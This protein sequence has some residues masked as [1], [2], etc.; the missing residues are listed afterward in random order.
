MRVAMMGN[1]RSGSA[2][3]SAPAVVG[4]VV[5]DHPQRSTPTGGI[6]VGVDDSASARAAVA[7]A[8]AEADRRALE[9]HLV[10][11]LPSAGGSGG[12]DGVPHGRA[13]ALLF[14]AAGIA[15]ARCPSL[16]VTMETVSGRVGPALVAYSAHADL[17]VV[18]SNGPGGP[19]PLSLG[20]IL[21]EVTA[22]AECPVVLVPTTETRSRAWTGPI[23]VALDGTPDG[24]RALVFAADAAHRRGVALV[25]LSAAAERSDPAGSVDT[26]EVGAT[27]AARI[28]E[29]HPGLTIQAQDIAGQPDDALLRAG[30][31]AALIV[32]PARHRGLRV[33]GA[34]G[35]WTNRFL[36]VLSSCPVAVVPAHRSG[37]M[38]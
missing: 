9:L 34:S 36:P 29:D 37:D 27:A 23:L 25:T 2:E 4:G 10:E 20:S 18:G 32:I 8:A 22:H 6:V 26:Q 5:T 3:S 35:A 24:E 16:P 17:L 7:W 31:D 30:T 12:T 11:V 33:A 38:P 21:G 28:R 14:R 1:E 15:H 19:I 13:R